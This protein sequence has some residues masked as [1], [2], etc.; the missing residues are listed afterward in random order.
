MN[1][2]WDIIEI[3][4]DIMRKYT[5]SYSY[6]ICTGGGYNVQSES[7]NKGSGNRRRT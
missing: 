7:G 3:V 6:N 5:I 2:Y 4:I 1:F